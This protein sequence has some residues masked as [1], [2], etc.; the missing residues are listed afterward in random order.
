MSPFTAE[1]LFNNAA[2]CQTE[3]GQR[4]FREWL[5][6][7]H[8]KDEE[9]E[10]ILAA[11]SDPVDSANAR[12]RDKYLRGN[13]K[14]P[15]AA[16]ELGLNSYALT[17]YHKFCASEGRGIP[18]RTALLIKRRRGEPAAS[19]NARLNGNRIAACRLSGHR[20]RLGGMPP[21]RS[22]RI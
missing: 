16:A 11:C 17:M 12:E 1:W 3:E 22:V 9:Y 7:K 14:W 13:P 5:R 2:Y 6:Y 15:L 10:G 18:V 8:D 20:R 21:H 4:R 19:W